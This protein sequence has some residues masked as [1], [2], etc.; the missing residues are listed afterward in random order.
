MGHGR[1]KLIKKKVN[2]NFDVAVY[3]PGY[4]FSL[5]SHLTPN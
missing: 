5:S 2:Y 4:S 1:I 3:S